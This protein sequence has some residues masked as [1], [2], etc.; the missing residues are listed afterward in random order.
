MRKNYNCKECHK[1]LK[2]CHI[3]KRWYCPDCDKI[4]QKLLKKM[5]DKK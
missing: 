1:D 3:L 5:E 2:Y 4:Q